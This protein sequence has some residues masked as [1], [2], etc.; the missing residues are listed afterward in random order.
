MI[1]LVLGNSEDFPRRQSTVFASDGL[2]VANARQSE[3]LF[4]DCHGSDEPIGSIPLDQICNLTILRWARSYA[5]GRYI[6]P[7]DA[8][9]CQQ[10]LQY[11]NDPHVVPRG[12]TQCFSVQALSPLDVVDPGCLGRRDD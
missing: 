2:Q 3:M 6:S 7:N 4:S 10:S 11:T 9:G 12:V 8:R 5:L 1:Y